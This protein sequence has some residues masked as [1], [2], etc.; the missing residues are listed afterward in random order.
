[1]TCKEQILALVSFTTL[2]TKRNLGHIN[3]S[4]DF[5]DYYREQGKQMAE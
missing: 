1:M 4:K 3:F 5:W 2:E